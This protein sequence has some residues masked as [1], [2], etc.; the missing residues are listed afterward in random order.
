MTRYTEIFIKQISAVELAVE[1]WC[2]DL[3]TTT[4]YQIEVERICREAKFLRDRMNLLE[5]PEEL[6]EFHM[7]WI[8]SVDYGIL[9]FEKSKILD[10][11]G[12]GKYS[13]MAAESMTY[14]NIL[15]V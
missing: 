5:V 13:G 9:A 1:K 6:K 11:E 14:A 8:Q 7:Y 12:A 4:E 15:L 10:S 3:I 2:S